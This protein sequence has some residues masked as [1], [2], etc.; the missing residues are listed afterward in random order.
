MTQLWY[1]QQGIV[2][3]EMEYIAIRENLGREE[4]VRSV[5]NKQGARN[6]LNQQHPGCCWLQD[7]GLYHAR[8]RA[9]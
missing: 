3:P 7:S 8:I 1:A 4:A 6:I 2:T 9:G 5:E